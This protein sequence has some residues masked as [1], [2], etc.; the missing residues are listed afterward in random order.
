MDSKRTESF[1]NADAGN[2][3]NIKDPLHEQKTFVTFSHSISAF[4]TM[5]PQT[6]ARVDEKPFEIVGPTFSNT[7]GEFRKHFCLFIFS[8]V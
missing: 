4:G 5:S 2:A 3:T 1:E 8:S 6:H 7:H